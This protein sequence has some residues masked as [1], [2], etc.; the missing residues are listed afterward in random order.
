VR[1]LPVIDLEPLRRFP[2]FRRLWLGL[3]VSQV[4]SQLTLVAVFYQV[5]LL[6]G[7]SLDVGLVSLA[8][9]GPA[10]VGSLLGGSVADA[11]DR[12]KMLVVTQLAMALCSVG[13]ALNSVGG[14]PALWPIF[15]LAALSAGFSGAEMKGVQVTLNLQAT[16]NVTL[17]VGESKTSVEVSGSGF[18]SP[19]GRISATVGGRTAAVRCFDRTTCTMRIPPQPGRRATDSVVVITDSGTSNPLAFRLR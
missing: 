1:H 17:Q 13:L 14:K 12:R 4:G 2:Q 5:Y 10:L 11:I 16:A 15:V 18:L 19:S 9:L 7:S 8:Q 3:A 6:T